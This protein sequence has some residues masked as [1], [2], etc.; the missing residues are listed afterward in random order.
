MSLLF[1]GGN[2][3]KLL[4][5]GADYFPALERAIRKA[6]HEVFLETYIYENDDTGRFIADA[7]CDAAQRG[8]ATHLMVDGF[9]AKGM[10]KKLSA[11]LREA[12]VRLLVYRPQ[13]SMLTLRRERLRR[14]HR[15][16]AV[17][18]GRTAFVGGINI[19]DDVQKPAN[20][21]PRYDYAVQI[22]GPLVPG[23]HEDAVKLWRRVARSRLSPREWLRRRIVPDGTPRGNQRAAFVVRDN[24]R[25]RSDI[26]KAYLDAIAKARDEI[27][28]ANAYF[29]PG[30]RFRRALVAAARRGVK[31]TLLLQGRVEYLLQ[32]YATRALYGSF[33]QA[34]VEIRE[35][36]RSFLH[37]KVAVID[38]NWATVG[39]SNIDPF[40]LF[41]A[42]EANVVTDDRRFA[43]ELH[44]SLHKAMKEGALMLPRDD[45]FRQPWW[46]RAP[47]WI[48][49]GIA[50][51][52]L[53]V[54]GFGNKL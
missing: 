42:R 36:H 45:W 19:L 6:R 35:Y 20:L 17:V 9:G 8:V 2:R 4:N 30:R 41:L 18:D 52:L 40:S 34:G 27:V 38:R 14:M 7:L 15:K 11:R 26:E 51:L 13:I 32:H 22:E 39:S 1:L 49:Y 44:R 29:F 46:K 24:V 31:V 10:P 25:H 12:G 28:I 21:P 53:G 16:V 54:A 5:T 3:L 33:L 50:R 23:I 48:C 37:A 47:V 43:T